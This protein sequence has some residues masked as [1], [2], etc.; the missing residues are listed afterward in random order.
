MVWTSCRLRND[1]STVSW[2]RSRTT[3][4]LPV[5]PSMASALRA[6][7]VLGSGKSH[8]ST[9]PTR[10]MAARSDRAERRASCTIFL[11]VRW[12]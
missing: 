10:P 5:R 8:D 3:R 12:A 1:R 9:T 7:L 4:I 2:S 6:S 11:G